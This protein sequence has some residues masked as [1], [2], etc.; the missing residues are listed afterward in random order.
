[1]VDVFHSSLN[2]P[3]IVVSLKTDYFNR[4]TSVIILP[5]IKRKHLQDHFL[6]PGPRHLKLLDHQCKGQ[7]LLE[8]N[9]KTQNQ[10][11]RKYPARLLMQP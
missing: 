5:S 9:Y 1:M 8:M 6:K 7:D 11:F 10:Q 2:S 3:E 4:G